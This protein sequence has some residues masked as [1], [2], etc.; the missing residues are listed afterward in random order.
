MVQGKFNILPK[1]PTGETIE[2]RREK[3]QALLCISLFLTSR[4]NII[5]SSNDDMDGVSLS[6]MT[7]KHLYVLLHLITCMFSR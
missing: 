4:F 7:W 1:Q 2:N 3:I 6:L 5:S